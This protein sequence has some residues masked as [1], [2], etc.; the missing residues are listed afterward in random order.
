M[1]KLFSFFEPVWKYIDNGSFFREP[2][3]WLYMLLAC[4]NLLFPLYIIYQIIDNRL[5]RNAPGGIIFAAILVILVMLALGVMFFVFWI[6]R[7]E[8]IKELYENDTDFVAIPMVAHL[9]QSVGEWLGLYVGIFGF[10]VALML[11]IFGLSEMP[12][13]PFEGGV[14]MI[15]SYPIIGF[16]I[17][18]FCRLLAEL[19]RAVATIANNTKRIS[20]R[21]DGE[22]PKEKDSFEE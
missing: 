2:F 19:Y 4:L 7:Q 10:F 15:I 8:R 16:L 17:V 21:M 22:K 12:G 6:K 18:V 20:D 9:V 13:F 11:T 1:D 14:S 5:L 3:R